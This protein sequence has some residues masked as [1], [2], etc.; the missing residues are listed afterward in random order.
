M[1]VLVLSETGGHH[2]YKMV[3]EPLEIAEGGYE[4]M[5]AFAGVS[6]LP[7]ILADLVN[8]DNARTVAINASKRITTFYLWLG[9]ICYIG[10]AKEM[11]TDNEFIHRRQ[12]M[13]I[14]HCLDDYYPYAA[15]GICALFFLKTVTTFPL[16]FWPLYREVDALIM[17]DETPAVKLKLPWAIRRQYHMKRVVKAILIVLILVPALVLDQGHFTLLAFACVAFATTISQFIFP[18]AAL[19]LAMRRHVEL[20][21]SRKLRDEMREDCG[22]PED[23]SS[24]MRYMFG[25]L[26]V[27]YAAVHVNAVVTILLAA[28]FCT[29]RFFQVLRAI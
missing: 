5:Y 8:P 27:H 12:P 20:L 28:A 15:M 10:W 14:M 2:S 17:F 23:S 11:E 19:A 25:S 13:K 1:Y 24:V 16:L 6:L 21:E 4:M 26:K 3:G 29:F 18:A 9:I 7:Y 22:N